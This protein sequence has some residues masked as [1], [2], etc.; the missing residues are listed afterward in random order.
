M[1]DIKNEYYNTL[2][3]DKKEIY[4]ILFEGSISS[5]KEFNGFIEKEL[6][7]R[8]KIKLSD[9]INNIQ[10]NNYSDILISFINLQKENDKINLRF[11]YFKEEVSKDFLKNIADADKEISF[12][13]CIFQEKAY[14]T[15][16]TFENIVNF[17]GTEFKKWTNFNRTKF[18]K[19][20]S[21][22]S[23][24]F[25]QEVEFKE[26]EFHQ[27]AQFS[28]S[29][30]EKF[31][32]FEE[33][34]FFNKVDFTNTTSEDLFYFHNVSLGELNLI[35]SHLD[36]ANFLRLH[37][38][39]K[40][41]KVLTKKNFNNKDSAR[42][43]KAHFENENNITEANMYFVIEQEY[44]LDLLCKEDSKY[45]N[46]YINLT[47]LLVSKYVSTFGTDWLKVLIIIFGFGFLASFGY[48]FLESCEHKFLF[49]E[50][51]LLLF[52]G[53]LYSLIL[54]NL[55]ED[56]EVIL[57]L[58][59]SAI[60]IILF[61]SFPEVRKTANDIATLMNPLNMFKPN[62]EYF[63]D[64]VLYGLLIKVI[65]SGLFYQ[66]IIAFRNSSRRK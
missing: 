1:A 10:D 51:K 11:I 20:C 37:N 36:K 28:S 45:P 14:F 49:S 34:K 31:A 12:A 22:E 43:I 30:F 32:S 13:N 46:R 56:K 61:I 3:E 57:F 7:G 47:S 4:K 53:F 15:D 35:G 16:L 23:V 27:N 66:F 8:C 62:K 38:N 18:R 65:I 63:K 41:N 60:Y 55:Y 26:T 21:F 64:I 19:D 29:R 40:N 24:K 33:A 42:M 9:K 54:Y 5:S 58:L 25:E 44:Y 17:E 2:D 52:I 48:G 39:D 50:Q 59:W 6:D